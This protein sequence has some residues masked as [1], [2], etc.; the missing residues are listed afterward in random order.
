MAGTPNILIIWGD[1]IGIS[2]VSAYSNGLM[3]YRTP[4]IDRIADEGVKFTDY[5]GEQSCTAGR[6]A[7]IT[8][9]NPYRSGL[10]KVGM[11]G[12]DLGLRA[13]DPTIATALKAEGYATGQ[14]G[15]N[16]LGDRDEFLP[17]AH[18]FDE[19]FGNLY[20]LNAEEEP[21]LPDYPTEADF[22][23]FRTR[24]GPRGVIHSWANADGT[25]RIEDTGPL[26]KKRMET[27][28]EEF[29]DAAI[30]FMRRKNAEEQ[31][32]FLWFNSTHMHFRTHTRPEDLGRAGR[33]Q[34]PYHDAMLYHDEIVGDLLDEL[35]ALGIAD[36][37]IVMY[38]TDNGPHMNSWPDAGMTPFRNEKNSNW[39][40]A[41]R[42]PAMVRWPG[43]IPAGTTLNG[44]V[45]H[46]D[47]FV[48]LLAAVGNDHIAADLREGVELGGIR[49]RVHLDGH[50]QLAYI[51]GAAEESPRNF[52]FY[53]SDDGDLTALRYDNW[54]VVFLEQRA[55]GTL[56]IWQEPFTELRFP[57][58]F[59]LRT[60]PYERADIT[61]NTYW[62][63]VL[64]H[65][66][67]FIPAQAF[68]AEMLQT[69]A[70]FPRRQEPASFNLDKVLAK[71]QDAGA[72]AS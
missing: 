16:H 30:D 11:P 29:R 72:G 9:Q 21:E 66:F 5:Y 32:F 64:D 67:L 51:T 24:F 31:P 1:D 36:D 19:F 4:N 46:N 7:F 68:V 40:G 27:C 71:L 12:A 65:I 53:V 70:E 57:K 26:T 38:S 8:G 17:T 50:N 3:G 44:I 25:Q 60:D 63:W 48:T 33:W 10:T 62:D 35:E 42:V 23:N 59:N 20:H 28:D 18:G 52:F 34:S 55:T 54:K 69:L 41:Y 47:W 61:S 56:Q 39:E 58:L 22:P 43:H 6:A 13:E 2:N 45:S 15:K 14:F 49:Y 37:T